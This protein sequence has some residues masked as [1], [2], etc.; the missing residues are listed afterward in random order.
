MGGYAAQFNL[1][2]SS[3][4]LKGSNP[5]QGADAAQELSTILAAIQPS[6]IYT[7]NPLDKHETHNAVTRTVI[8]AAR[9]L[10][11]D[12]QPTTFIGCEVWRGLDWAEAEEGIVTM[13]VSAHTELQGDLIALHDS[14]VEGDKNYVEATL[15]RQKAN[16]TYADPHKVDEATDI[17]YGLDLMPFIKD[18]SLT[19][20]AF[21]AKIAN[22][23]ADR[24]IERAET[25]EP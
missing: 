5:S 4:S 12:A 14:Q 20:K 11:K 24:L 10:S 7:H 18:P 1:H 19:N 21:T 13:D 16:A 23:Y 6:A 17:V 15:G 9:K 25:Y 2:Y 8:Q 3:K 22:A